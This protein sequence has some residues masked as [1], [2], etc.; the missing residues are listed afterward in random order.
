MKNPDVLNIVAMGMMVLA[1]LE[2]IIAYAVTRKSDIRETTSNVAIWF[3]QRIWRDGFAL[4][5][6]IAA[7]TFLSHHVPYH[8]P[9][10]LLVWVLA[11]FVA[12][13]VYYWKHRYEHE[14]RFLW[15]YHSV[16][17]SSSY[18]NLS[19]AIRLPI[20]GALSSTFFH[21]P[22]ILLGFSP[23]MVLVGRSLVLMYQYWIHTEYIGKLGWVEDYLN[24]PSNHRVHHGSNPHYLDK[25]YT[26]ILIGWDKLFGTY[27]KEVEKVIYGLTTPIGTQNPIKINFLEPLA[28]VKDIVGSKSLG[29]AFRYAFGRP[30]WKPKEGTEF[31]RGT[32]QA[33]VGSARVFANSVPTSLHPMVP[34][35]VE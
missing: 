12:D 32:A 19:T 30:G 18:Y 6:T 7:F 5:G 27:E 14:V 9:S 29:D 31:F 13:F 22:M 3:L 10:N 26:G 8:L 16:H 28:I 2:G 20:L 24:T 25:N 21:A 1:A 23:A 15:A 4:G 34:T 11:V 35:L 17:H 33:A